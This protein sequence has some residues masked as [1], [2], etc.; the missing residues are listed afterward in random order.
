LLLVLLAGEEVRGALGAEVFFE[1]P[2]FGFGEVDDDEA[3]EGV[4]EGGVDVEAGEAAAEF[5]V[6]AEE[7]GDGALCA[8]DFCYCLFEILDGIGGYGG[9]CPAGGVAAADEAGP[10]AEPGGLAEE[11]DDEAAGGVGVAVGDGD[12]AEQ[13]AVIGVGGDPGADGFPE[14]KQ[15]GEAF[16]VFGGDEAAAELE[17]GAEFVEEV[18]FVVEEGGGVEIGDA[19]LAGEDGLHAVGAGDLL[20]LVVVEEEV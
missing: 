10:I 17:G 14:E 7:D 6:L 9:F 11:G 20:T 16:L 12:G 15:G 5:E 1:L 2:G 18:L 4:G 13:D 8:F 3:V 19:G